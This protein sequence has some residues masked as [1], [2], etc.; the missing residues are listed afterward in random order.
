ADACAMP[1]CTARAL[2]K[3]HAH[4]TPGSRGHDWRNSRRVPPSSDV[5]R[6]PRRRLTLGYHAT[7]GEGLRLELALKRLRRADEGQ[8]AFGAA[9]GAARFGH[10][11]HFAIAADSIR[12]KSGPVGCMDALPTAMA[13]LS[14][15]S[16]R[17][18]HPQ[19]ERPLC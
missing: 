16:V 9:S 18:R 13:P 19:A 17:L 6:K 2:A 12:W 7:K 10:A 11:S 1:D 4:S 14:A 15:T 5:G 3:R 8:D